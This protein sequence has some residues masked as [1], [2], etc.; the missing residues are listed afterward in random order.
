VA[1][2]LALDLAV[3]QCNAAVAQAAIPAL[4]AAGSTVGSTS[5]HN[6]AFRPSADG[7]PAILQA[8][9]AGGADPNA[10]DALSYTPLVSTVFQ[11]ARV[12]CV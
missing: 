8:L 9:L 1:L 6:I 4:V 11:S 2:D 12:Q 7:V 10:K 5:I 3:S